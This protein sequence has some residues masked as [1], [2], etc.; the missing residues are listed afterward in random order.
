MHD[1]G[2]HTDEVTVKSHSKKHVENTYDF[3]IFSLS[4]YVAVS[5]RTQSGQSEI[6]TQQV[7]M[8]RRVTDQVVPSVDPI[9]GHIIE[10]GYQVPQT[11]HQMDNEQNLKH[12]D[13]KSHDPR[14]E[15]KDIGEKSIRGQKFE[16]F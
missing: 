4:R 16:N 2:E 10:L 15:I 5:D 12:S 14:V 3:F 1:T 13:K 9:F 7:E 11:A 6:Q 8:E